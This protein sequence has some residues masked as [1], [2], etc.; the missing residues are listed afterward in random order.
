MAIVKG[1]KLLTR[2]KPKTLE[3]LPSAV[4]LKTGTAYEITNYGGNIAVAVNGA[5]RF[6]FP[7]RTT[8]AGRPAVGLVPAG[9]ELQVTDI[10][11][12]KFISDGTVWRP[13]QGRAMLALLSGS[14]S[15][16]LATLSAVGIFSLPGG[17]TKIPAG[18]IIPNSRVCASVQF[19]K[20]GSAAS[21]SV[22][23][24]IGT[25]NSSA[26]NFLCGGSIANTDTGDMKAQGFASF[27]SNTTRYTS[28]GW[29][30]ENSG[31]Y[32]SVAVDVTTNVNTAA[33]MWVNPAI[34][35]MTAPDSAR[36]L[37]Y[38]VWLEA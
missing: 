35:T 10:N 9:T 31:N 26:D 2:L 30:A 36:V 15:M 21:M 5:W 33:D 22:N 13:A 14:I 38:E 12:Q 19:R 7:F 29:Q 25:T 16:P 28:G 24:K 23:A 1:A 27:G 11:N 18:M 17:G 32:G 34:T 4:G 37:S 6:E 8:W 3:G 20:Y